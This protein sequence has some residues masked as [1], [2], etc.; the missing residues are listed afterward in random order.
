MHLY[1]RE[2]YFYIAQLAVSSHSWLYSCYNSHACVLKNEILCTVVYCWTDV[3]CI[4]WVYENTD[5]YCIRECAWVGRLEVRIK[6]CLLCS[7]L[8]G[9]STHLYNGH[10][11]SECVSHGTYNLVSNDSYA[12]VIPC[13]NPLQIP[14]LP[15]MELTG[16]GMQPNS[17]FTTPNFPPPLSHYSMSMNHQ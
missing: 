4:L 3:H 6:I 16:V 17:W 7:C 2:C 9:S 13:P 8:Q 10:Y 14:S 1:S 15:P 12:E 11:S 5:V